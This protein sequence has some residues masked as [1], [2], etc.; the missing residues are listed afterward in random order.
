MVIT[1][2][3]NEIVLKHQSSNP[4]VI[5]GDR[6]SLSPQLAEHRGVMVS[7]LI[8][9]EQDGYAW[10]HQE[11]AQNAFVF[12]S[13]HPADKACTQFR[14]HCKRKEDELRMLDQRDYPF[15]T[16]AQVRISI[17][18]KSKLHFHRCSSIRSCSAIT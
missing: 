11:A 9:R 5:D 15:M 1:V 2:A 3:E 16:P 18:V 8:V 12:G 13:P 7:R 14:Q 10:L 4:K 6:R 17:G